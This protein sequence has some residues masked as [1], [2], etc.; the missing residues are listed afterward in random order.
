MQKGNAFSTISS[1]LVHTKLTPKKIHN[2]N[3]TSNLSTKVPSTRTWSSTKTKLTLE[4]TEAPTI[5][6]RHDRHRRQPF[7]GRFRYCIALLLA[8]ATYSYTSMRMNLG[9]AMVGG[10]E[11][12]AGV[13]REFWIFEIRIAIASGIFPHRPIFPPLSSR[14][15]GFKLA[16]FW[17]HRQYW[18]KGIEWYHHTHAIQSSLNEVGKSKSGGIVPFCLVRKCERREM[19]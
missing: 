18:M 9:M 3:G 1:A 5:P 6:A 16:F 2:N 11:L 15:L 14:G 13:A 10:L 8:L 17:F 4:S 19:A 12:E 7:F